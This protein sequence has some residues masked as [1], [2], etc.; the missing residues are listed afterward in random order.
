MPNRNPISTTL[1]GFDDANDRMEALLETEAG[2][3]TFPG[4]SACANLLAF[5]KPLPL[6]DGYSQSDFQKNRSCLLPA[7]EPF[8]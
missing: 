8:G 6:R 1:P 7:R 2:N 4:L 3:L 5:A